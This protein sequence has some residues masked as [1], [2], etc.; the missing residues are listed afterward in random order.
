MVHVLA[1]RRAGGLEVV[2]I[3]GFCQYVD[4]AS[5]MVILRARRAVGS[6]EGRLDTP[7]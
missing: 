6:A 1:F 3:L 2:S 5:T 4:R 7:D